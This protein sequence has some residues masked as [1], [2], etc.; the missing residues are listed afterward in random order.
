MVAVATSEITRVRSQR[1]R[2]STG[3][4][5]LQRWGDLVVMWQW[6]CRLTD[7]ASCDPGKRCSQRQGAGMQPAGSIRQ[8]ASGRQAS[9]C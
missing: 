6:L 5:R 4:H 9:A 7:A 3:G 2:G 1:G 8:A